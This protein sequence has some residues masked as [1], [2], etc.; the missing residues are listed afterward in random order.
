MKSYSRRS[1]SKVE[2]LLAVEPTEQ[3]DQIAHPLLSELGSRVGTE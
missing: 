1:P 3:L 2:A